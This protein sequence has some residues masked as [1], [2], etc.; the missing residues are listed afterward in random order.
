METFNSAATTPTVY[1]R[2]PAPTP[3]L[4][5]APCSPPTEPR[6]GPVGPTVGPP[7][8]TAWKL[9]DLFGQFF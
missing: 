8:G 4:F 5:E 7:R 9:G 1:M 6:K 3:C 2:I